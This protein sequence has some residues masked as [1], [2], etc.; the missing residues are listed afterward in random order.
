M[1]SSKVGHSDLSE[2]SDESLKEAIDNIVEQLNSYSKEANRRKREKYELARKKYEDAKKNLKECDV[3]DVNFKDFL[4]SVPI[5]G[6]P[7]DMLF[8]PSLTRFPK[9]INFN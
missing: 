5:A 6:S 9:I 8:Q 7:L 1:T 2:M 4:A 3:F